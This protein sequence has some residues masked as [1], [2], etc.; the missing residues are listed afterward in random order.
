[1]NQK[2]LFTNLFSFLV[3]ILILLPF[4]TSADNF[5]TKIVENN[6]LYGF[7]QTNI[8]PVEAKMMGVVLSPFGYRY[9][10]SPTNST[11]VVNGTN[12]QITWN[13]I[14][15]QSMLLFLLSIFVGL[16]RRYKISSMFIAVG[17]GILGTFWVNI[18]RMLFTVVLAVDAPAIFRVVFH[19]YLAAI[20]TIIW[21][22]FFWWFSYSYVLEENGKETNI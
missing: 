19:D 5:L 6:S 12:M 17:I 18:F 9:A 7:V 14:G 21:L 8:V 22:F 4:L 1:M 3:I 16:G 11:I 2:K 10:Y 13:C 20:V 15:W